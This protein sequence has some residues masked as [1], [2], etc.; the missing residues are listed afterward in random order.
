MYKI[1][2]YVDTSVFGGT[3]DEQFAEP[4][5]RFFDR[6]QNGEFIVLLSAHTVDELLPAPEQIM[7]VL[8]DLPE[9]CVERIASGEEVRT[10]AEAY[11]KAGALGEAS[12]MDALH[13]AAATVAR[14]ELILSWNFKHIVNYDRIHM[15]NGVNVL[16]G[17]PAVEIYSPLELNYGNEDQNI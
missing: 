13:V 7:Q 12:R 10:L 4:S 17:Y 2:S 6:V 11:I 16:N 5:R 15:F 8:R 1:R 3:Q 9:N 14:A